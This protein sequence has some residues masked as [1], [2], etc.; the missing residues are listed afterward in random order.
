MA[1]QQLEENRIKPLPWPEGAELVLGNPYDFRPALDALMEKVE[2]IRA[3]LPDKKIVIPIGEN[4]IV[5]AHDYFQAAFIKA[6]AG[7]YPGQV[8]YGHETQHNYM[9]DTIGTVMDT[10]TSERRGMFRAIQRE[11]FLKDV[12]FSHYSKLKID[13]TKALSLPMGMND[14][15]HVFMRP[16]KKQASGLNQQK[17]WVRYCD[18][19][20]I[21]TYEFIQ[22]RYKDASPPWE[23]LIRDA[24]DD[25]LVQEGIRVSNGFMAEK[26]DQHFADNEAQIYI[27]TCGVAHLIGYVKD[28]WEQEYQHSLTHQLDPDKYS[29]LPVFLESAMASVSDIPA[30]GR[31]VLS[32]DGLI[33]QGLDDSTDPDEEEKARY[34]ATMG[35]LF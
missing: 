24:Q 16:Q 4:H 29:V 6:I 27:Q 3:V 9:A 5:F 33:V 22:R 20:D 30:E 28:K 25:S 17:G 18:S 26:I 10:T 12:S 2:Q 11:Y 35:P 23:T 14:I 15:A 21:D 8:A 32:K 13:M 1:A 31:E 34:D 19:A 7:H